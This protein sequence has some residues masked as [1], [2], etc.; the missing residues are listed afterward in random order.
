VKRLVA[1]VGVC[2]LIGFGCAAGGPEISGD[3]RNVGGVTVTFKV[4]P[5]RAKVGQS[6]GVTFRL[7][8]NVGRAEELSFPSGQRYDFW[9]TRNGREV[10]RWSK[11]R[12]FVAEVT[13]E[14]L[15]PQSGITFAERWTPD[16]PGSYIVH[17]ELK[18][19]GYG[20][21]LTGRLEVQ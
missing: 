1:L 17:G 8:N 14:S 10:W 18:A 3:L 12:V 2:V 13:R 21:D 7:V 6:V 9:A 20:R 5:A 11:G 15:A 4:S 16:E 19:E